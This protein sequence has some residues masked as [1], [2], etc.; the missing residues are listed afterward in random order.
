MEANVIGV[1]KLT[2]TGELRIPATVR[3]RLRALLAQWPGT[4]TFQ[5]RERDGTLVLEPAHTEHPSAYRP[6]QKEVKAL[7]ARLQEQMAP[8]GAE[9]PSEDDEIVAG[10]AW[11]EY[12]ALSDEER[13]QVWDNLTAD[14][15]P[16]EDLPVVEVRPDARVPAGQKH[17]P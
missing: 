16:L 11:R 10:L 13:E 15:P 8:Y 12:W 6:S 2:P 9:P 7:V 3:E 14:M 1:V 17:R 5:V 4:D